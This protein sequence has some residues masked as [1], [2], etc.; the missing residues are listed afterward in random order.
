MPD[1]KSESEGLVKDES[2]ERAIAAC[3]DSSRRIVPITG[4]AGTGKTTILKA[5][6]DHFE[7]MGRSVVLGS[8]FG[9]AAKRITEATGIQACTL[10]RL[11]EYPYPGE[12]D[13]KTGKPLVTTDPKRDHRNPLDA[14]VVLVDEYTVV[15]TELHRNLFDALP[16]GGLIRVFGDANQLYPIEGNDHKKKI[17]P[18][19]VALLRRFN[20]I[21]LTKIH[22]QQEDSSIIFNCHR[23][24]QGQVPIRRDDFSMT[25]TEDPVTAIQDLVMDGYQTGKDYGS[26]NCQII[27]PTR[28]GWIGTHSIN[29]TIQS[30]LQPADKECIE[31]AR[32][33]WAPDTSLRIFVGDKVIFTCNNYGLSI[34]N[35]ET[36]VVKEIDYA[37]IITIDFGD[38]IIGI[39]PIMEVTTRYGTGHIN[40]QKDIDLAYAI[41]TH[42]AQG[43]EYDHVAYVI[44]RSRPFLLNRRNFYTAMSRARKSA[45]IITDQRAL[46]LSLY[47]T[48][49]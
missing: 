19:F 40:P 44:N 41:S 33:P 42:K 9:K 23:I 1:K 8:A 46:S 17:E 48:G 30:M 43:S 3:T 2:Q 28:V 13:Q 14:D 35:G 21:W 39:P 20:G 25:I 4:E 5:V 22:R 31:I 26:I 34:F 15:N 49:E 24:L 38:R 18:P 27:T 47:K 10:H 45:H 11:L 7:S 12:V 37:G 36:G 6:H 16:A 32:H 29:G